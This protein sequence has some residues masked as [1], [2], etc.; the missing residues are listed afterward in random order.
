[1]I[2]AALLMNFYPVRYLHIG[3]FMDRNPWFTMTTLTLLLVF[4]FTPWFGY[5]VFSQMLLYV[6]SPLWTWR[7][8]PEIAA[9]ETRK[10]RT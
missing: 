5:M 3:R 7:I 6:I 2:F 9:L 1:M 8:D 4:I 10:G